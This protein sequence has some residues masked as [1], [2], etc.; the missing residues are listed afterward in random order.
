[1]NDRG[2]FSK[3]RIIDVSSRG[4]ELLVFKNHGIAKVRVT[5]M[6]RES[7]KIAQAAMQGMDTRGMMGLERGEPQYTYDFASM[8]NERTSGEINL[9]TA[10]DK[11]VRVHITNGH[12]YPDQVV[13]QEEVVPTSVYIQ[14]GAFASRENAVKLSQEFMAFGSAQIFEKQVM[15]TKFYRVRITAGS[16]E[17]AVKLRGKIEK[18]GHKDAL[19]TVE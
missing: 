14:V 12:F 18:A 9:K 1:M 10:G 3:N 2:H 19:I 15:H 11:I 16:P 4:A 13:T 7:K 6:E 17:D 8:K 5:I